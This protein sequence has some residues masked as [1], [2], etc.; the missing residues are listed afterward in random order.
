MSFRA[1][2]LEN[3]QWVSREV[4]ISHAYAMNCE[5]TCPETVPEVDKPPKVPVIGVLTRCVIRS[6]VIN[7]ILSVRVRASGKNC[8]VFV[9]EDFMHFKEVEEDGHLRHLETMDFGSR[10]RAARVFGEPTKPE[11]NPYGKVELS[12]TETLPAQ[13]IVF[14]LESYELVFLSAREAADGSIDLDRNSVPLP[15]Q[16]S[17]LEQPG[18][19]IA[20]DPKARAIAV[21]ACENMVLLYS[22]K[23]AVHSEEIP[24]AKG[25]ERTP[26]YEERPLDVVGTI[27]RMEFLY[28]AADDS[29]HVILLLVVAKNGRSKLCCYDWDDSIGLRSLA[30]RQQQPLMKRKTSSFFGHNRALTKPRGKAT[31]HDHTVPKVLELHARM[32]KSDICI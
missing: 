19:H 8:V 6:P 1:T 17:F 11:M 30:P 24:T 32:R 7:C 13:W 4:D 25:R 16:R 15:A 14:T 9:G 3:G 26:I 23:S 18:K 22:A 10:I 31:A 21:A 2:V 20:V 5:Q 27:V 12:N 28:P 29:N